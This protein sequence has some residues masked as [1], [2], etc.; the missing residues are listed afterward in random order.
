MTATERG[1]LFVSRENRIY[2]ASRDGKDGFT[3]LKAPRELF[4]RYGRGPALGQDHAYFVSSGGELCGGGLEPG[5]IQTLAPDARAGARVSV[6]R[7]AGR[8]LVGYIAG[9]GEEALGMLWAEG[10]R[11]HPVESIR[12]TPEGAAATSITLVPTT[13][14]PHAVLLE[15]RTGMS[16]LHLRRLLV[17]ARR[18]TPEEDEVVWVGPGSHP[19]TEIVSLGSGGKVVSF[20]ATA[21]DVSHFGLA[22]LTLDPALHGAVE[23]SWRPYPNGL[24]PAPV[25]AHR[26]CGGDFAV[27]AVPQHEKPRAP[28]DLVLA[29]IEGGLLGKEEVLAHSRAYNDISVAAVKGGAIVAWTADHRTWAMVIGCTRN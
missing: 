2:L 5:E 4:S 9:Q 23:P 20:V 6:L 17:T 8:D 22:Q 25:A 13:P 11:G 15:G 16:P 3:A 18:I 10:T 21:K 12:L 1:V 14:H 19:L 27:Y 26:F 24:D 29:P 7:A 28:Q